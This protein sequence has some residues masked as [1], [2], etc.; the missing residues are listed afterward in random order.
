MAISP[1]AALLVRDHFASH[2]HSLPAATA[3]ACLSVVIAAVV[4]PLAELNRELWRFTSLAE[5]SRLQL[6]VTATV[7]F[8]LL[9]TFAH[10]RLLDISRSL[11]LLQWFF[12]VADDD[13]D[14]TLNSRLARK[15]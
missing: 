13:G 8:A 7:L 9:A 5:L 11:P 3:Y 2:G 4:F 14:K 12:L 10:T 6:A 15:Q 1:F